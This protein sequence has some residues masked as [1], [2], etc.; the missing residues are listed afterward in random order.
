MI[1]RPGFIRILLLFHH[2]VSALEPVEPLDH[3]SRDTS[4]KFGLGGKTYGKDLLWLLARCFIKLLPPPD[5]NTR[6]TAP[7]TILFSIDKDVRLHHSQVSFL[8]RRTQETAVVRTVPQLCDRPNQQHSV[9]SGY[10]QHTRPGTKCFFV[11]LFVPWLFIVL[12]MTVDSDWM[13]DK[14]FPSQVRKLFQFRPCRLC[15]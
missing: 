12:H 1:C 10:R 2:D 11:R 9:R 3:A 6:L 14:V 13:F 15:L 4:G 5:R 8:K 7:K